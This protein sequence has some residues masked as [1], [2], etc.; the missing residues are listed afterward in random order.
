MDFKKEKNPNQ[1][2]AG[3][4]SSW[5]GCIFQ[6]NRIC[7]NVLSNLVDTQIPSLCPLFFLF[8]FSPKAFFLPYVSSVW[9][10]YCANMFTNG[11][12]KTLQIFIQTL[13]HRI[14]K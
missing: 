10:L 3:I 12:K 5:C 6:R 13:F 7:D 9:S 14:Y 11:I 4:Y 8:F 1:I 2:C